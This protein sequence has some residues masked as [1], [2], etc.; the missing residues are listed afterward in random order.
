[1]KTVVSGR[2]ENRSSSYNSGSS[3]SSSSSTPRQPPPSDVKHH[4]TVLGSEGA[5]LKRLL[6]RNSNQH[7]KTKVFQLFAKVKWMWN[8]MCVLPYQHCADPKI[9]ENYWRHT[10]G[11]AK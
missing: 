11:C 1:M 9:S 4:I 8:C 6:Y 3:S 10:A 2:A 5:I 7:G